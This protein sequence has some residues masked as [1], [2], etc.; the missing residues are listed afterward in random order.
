MNRRELLGLIGAMGTGTA[1]GTS[2]VLADGH[3]MINGKKLPDPLG[4]HHLHFCGIHCAKKD[5][6][7]QIITQHYYGMITT[8]LAENGFG[9]PPDCACR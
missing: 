7:I 2:H 6:R 3:A 5:S 9:L 1:F 4:N 8:R